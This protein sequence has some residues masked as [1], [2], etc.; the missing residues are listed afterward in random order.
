MSVRRLPKGE[1]KLAA[2]AYDWTVLAE[3]MNRPRKIKFCRPT[4]IEFQLAE[5]TDVLSLRT[6]LGI[7]RAYL[8]TYVQEAL[9]TKT[10]GPGRPKSKGTPLSK[11]NRVISDIVYEM[12]R[13]FHTD[14]AAK[15]KNNKEIARRLK[16]SKYCRCK[17][18]SEQTV[19]IRVGDAF[20]MFKMPRAR[21]IEVMAKMG[22]GEMI[23]LDGHNV[24]LLL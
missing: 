5:E 10:P 18:P 24:A 20:K 9:Q 12:S 14:P 11:K 8:R 21:A 22:A 3:A 23:V 2:L 19:R 7:M 13:L 15:T 1:E 6:E 16:T 17:L 4:R